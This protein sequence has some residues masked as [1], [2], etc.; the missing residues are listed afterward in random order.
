MARATN[1][2]PV[3][4][5]PVTSTV[6]SE[7]RILCTSS[8]S[9]VIAGLEWMKPGIRL[10]PASVLCSSELWP[11]WAR[12]RNAHTSMPNSTT[13]NSG[14]RETPPGSCARSA[15]EINNVA[16]GALVD[17]RVMI[18]AF[19]F[20]ASCWRSVSLLR[21][22]ISSARLAISSFRQPWAT[23]T[24]VRSSSPDS[25]IATRCAFVS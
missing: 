8:T 24:R 15:G 20:R 25:K 1:S 6:T 9:R 3:P 21:D 12:A 10:V 13:R 17:R 19:R 2:L 22:P 16:G 18:D 5:S 23:K 11:V 14:S 7:D 4:D